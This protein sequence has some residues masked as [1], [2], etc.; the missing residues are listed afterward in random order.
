MK[1]VWRRLLRRAADIVIPWGVGLFY[2]LVALG[3]EY[4]QRG[5]PELLGVLLALAQGVALRWRR[6]HPELVMG[7]ALAGGLA[8]WALSPDVVLPLAGLFALYS[9]AEA[10]PFRV[11]LAGLV[12]LLGVAALNF[13]TTTAE[14]SVFALVVVLGAWALG[15]ASRNRRLAVEEG[16][17]RAV[18]E[19]KAEIARELHDVIAHSV[20]VIVVQA[21]AADDVFESR[22]D[23]ARAALRSIE[24]TGRDTLGELRRLLSAARPDEG[25][26]ATSPQPGLDRLEELADGLRSAGLTVDVRRDGT[27]ATAL[28]AGIDL[29]AYRIV[30]EALTNTLRHAHATRAR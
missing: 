10:R 7:V 16:A 1:P 29:S 30:Q 19:E 23:Q 18:T 22:P 6:S 25:E 24:R 3:P 11:T 12:A 28:P 21:A 15:E 5:S 9:L 26:E 17:R 13:F 8:F 14:D 2:V 20:S 4:E 27:A